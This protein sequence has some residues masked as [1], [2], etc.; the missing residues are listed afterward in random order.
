M[1]ELFS[2][3]LSSLEGCPRSSGK[4]LRMKFGTIELR[5]S[6][7]SRWRSQTQPSAATTRATRHLPPQTRTSSPLGTFLPSRQLTTLL[8]LTCSNQTF[9]V[10]LSQSLKKKSFYYHT[11]RDDR[12]ILYSS[13]GQNIITMIFLSLVTSNHQMYCGLYLN[14]AKLKAKKLHQLFNL[15]VSHPWTIPYIL[16]YYG[17]FQN[18][19]FV[20]I[21]K[22]IMYEFRF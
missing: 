1:K 20:C 21:S 17:V 8:R 4:R 5:N 7:L 22:I 6:G 11:Y 15:I 19:S 2:L 3:Q 12:V 10:T 9:G 18:C 16:I 13:R 14:G